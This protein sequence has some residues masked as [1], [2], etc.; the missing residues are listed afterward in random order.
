[1]IQK[2]MSISSKFSSGFSARVDSSLLLFRRKLYLWLSDV[3]QGYAPPKLNEQSQLFLVENL[4]VS[5]KAMFHRRSK[6]LT[7][8]II[9]QDML[10]LSNTPE[11]GITLARMINVLSNKPETDPSSSKK[12]YFL[13]SLDP[14]HFSLKTLPK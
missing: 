1:M 10:E 4:T 9:F 2:R 8:S 7:F 6:E 12:N 3:M 11:N 14:L 5:I 13:Q